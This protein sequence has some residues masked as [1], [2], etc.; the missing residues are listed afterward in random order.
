VIFDQLVLCGT[1]FHLVNVCGLS[2]MHDMMFLFQSMRQ[3]LVFHMEQFARQYLA[4][5]T[6]PGSSWNVEKFLWMNLVES[7]VTNAQK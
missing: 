3:G 2:Y 1:N 4:T 7:S 5:Q 6:M